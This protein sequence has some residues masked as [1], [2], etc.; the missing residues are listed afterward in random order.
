VQDQVPVR[1][2]FHQRALEMVQQLFSGSAV[3]VCPHFLDHNGLAL[4]CWSAVASIALNGLLVSKNK[5]ARVSACVADF[6]E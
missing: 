4:D 5:P 6:S 1:L 2:Q 3:G